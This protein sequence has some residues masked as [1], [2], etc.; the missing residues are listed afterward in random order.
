MT[1][2]E[3]LSVSDVNESVF[4]PTSTCV[5]VETEVMRLRSI[6]VGVL[7]ILCILVIALSAIGETP[8]ASPLPGSDADGVELSWEGLLTEGEPVAVTVR[9]ANEAYLKAQWIGSAGGDRQ[10][11]R[12]IVHQADAARAHPTVAMAQQAKSWTT[13]DGFFEEFYVVLD[14][15]EGWQGT[16]TLVPSAVMSRILI[17]TAGLVADNTVYGV[18]IDEMTVWTSER[19]VLRTPLAYDEAILIDADPSAGFNYPFFLFVPGSVPPEGCVH[20]LV[21]GNNTGIPSDDFEIHLT[22]A[23][24]MASRSHPASIARRLGTPLLVPVFP[25]P[26]ISGMDDVLDPHSLEL[27]VMLITDGGLVRIDLQLIAMIERARGLLAASGIETHG[28]ILMHGFSASSHFACRFAAMHPDRVRAFV[29]GATTALPIL[30]VGS[31]E[32]RALTYPLGVSDLTRIT[33]DPFDLDAFRRVAQLYWMGD[34]DTTDSLAFPMSWSSAQR[35]TIRAVLGET[36]IPDR[37]EACQAIYRAA[38]V[39]ATFLTYPG[40][41]HQVTNFVIDEATAFLA[42]HSLSEEVCDE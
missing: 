19:P 14:W 33:G 2:P 10:T 8:G 20:L 32:G 23:R 11:V 5:R 26:G 30:P 28:K 17:C 13:P 7:T 9:V 31:W 35:E 16:V 39:P 4:R 1:V 27:D 21:E 15:V 22:P 18:S 24:T 12:L 37:W 34:E 36:M 6:R 40:L 42:S 41:G 3:S 38:S 25:R 29:A